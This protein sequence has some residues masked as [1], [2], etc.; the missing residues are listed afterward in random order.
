MNIEYLLIKIIKKDNRLDQG[1]KVKSKLEIQIQI[2]YQKKRKFSVKNLN[3][4][5]EGIRN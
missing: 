1:I 5:M 4:S 2:N 3:N